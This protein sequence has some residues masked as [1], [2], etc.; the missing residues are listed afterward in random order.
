MNQDSSCTDG[1][2]F[3]T[4]SP[5]GEKMISGEH[6][7][8][9]GESQGEG[10]KTLYVAGCE[11]ACATCV[12]LVERVERDGGVPVPTECRCK[13]GRFDR[14]VCYARARELDHEE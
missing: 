5:N 4:P 9:G 6:R 2:P 11:P 13:H 10:S 8:F 12:E 1:N 3:D 14:K 7:A